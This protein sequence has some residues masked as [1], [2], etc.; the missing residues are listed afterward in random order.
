MAASMEP[1]TPRMPPGFSPGSVGGSESWAKASPAKTTSKSFFLSGHRVTSTPSIDNVPS[2]IVPKARHTDTTVSETSTPHHFTIGSNASATVPTTLAAKSTLSTT[3]PPLLLGANRLRLSD[4]SLQPNLQSLTGARLGSVGKRHHATSAPSS[5][6]TSSSASATTSSAGPSTSIHLEPGKFNFQA[7]TQ[8]QEN[9]LQE[10]RALLAAQSSAKA[11]QPG[12]GGNVARGVAGDPHDSKAKDVDSVDFAG[13]FECSVKGIKTTVLYAY[14]GVGHTRAKGS[15]DSTEP[16]IQQFEHHIANN[17]GALQEVNEQN[18][19]DAVNHSISQLRNDLTIHGDYYTFVTNQNRQGITYQTEAE[20]MAAFRLTEKGN[21]VTDEQAAFV[22]SVGP[23]EQSPADGGAM[24]AVAIGDAPPYGIPAWDGVGIVLRPGAKTFDDIQVLHDPNAKE[25][26]GSSCRQLEA[27]PGSQIILGTD[28]LW[29]ACVGSCE[30]RLMT[31]LGIP[32]ETTTEVYDTVLQHLTEQAPAVAQK[33]RAEVIKFLFDS[34]SLGDYAIEKGTITQSEVLAPYGITEEQT[35]EIIAS[36]KAAIPEAEQR[37]AT[38]QKRSELQSLIHI[39]IQK[40]QPLREEISRLNALEKLGK[41]GIKQDDYINY[42]QSFE[43]ILEAA[44]DIPLN[45][46]ELIGLMK[47]G[48]YD[49][50][51]K[52]LSETGKSIDTALKSE[53]LSHS[54]LS[55]TRRDIKRQRTEEKSKFL[56]LNDCVAQLEQLHSSDDKKVLDFHD[57]LEKGGGIKE[58]RMSQS[59]IKARRDQIT[60][61]RETQ[62]GYQNELDALTLNSQ[63][64]PWAESTIPIQISERLLQERTLTM[65]QNTVAKE[66]R[67]FVGEQIPPMTPSELDELVSGKGPKFAVLKER[68]EARLEPLKNPNNVEAG[69]VQKLD[70]AELPASLREGFIKVGFAHL[71]L[72]QE[73]EHLTAETLVH[74]NLEYSD[75]DACA[76]MHTIGHTT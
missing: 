61:L 11:Y 50:I 40:N 67:R 57:F 44:K 48:R 6:Q 9:V 29:E 68:V 47:A 51:T 1:S 60:Q 65:V 34:R 49:L 32:G 63:L 46:E 75:D 7:A 76:V 22:L 53:Q 4:P 10:R 66:F 27:A 15:R 42:T 39:E 35:R 3:R 45:R 31:A 64:Y 55:P 62:T 37:H 69:L 74:T 26:G 5:I 2:D 38:S 23:R 36:G 52:A 43:T 56:A 19:G 41:I 54:R 21:N 25:A 17:L 72:Q 14:D 71:H 59:E 8:R 70:T 73:P 24:I 18:I 12:A 58:A 13:H 33:T 16:F 30:A 28:G 20:S